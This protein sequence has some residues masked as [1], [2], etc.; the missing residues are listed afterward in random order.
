M[1]KFTIS[2]LLLAVLAGSVSAAEQPGEKTR[3]LHLLQDD[4]Q[5]KQV[6]KIYELKHVSANDLTPFVLSF[7]KR[8][9]V[10]STVE[11]LN[12]TAGKKELLVVSTPS[13]NMKYVDE[14]ITALDHPAPLDANGSV[15][16][17]TGI[18][19]F[20]YQP[21]YRSSDDIVTIINTTLRNKG[22]AYRDPV[23]NLIYWKDTN[24]VGKYILGWVQ[25]LDH[26]LPQAELIFRVYQIRKSDL[27]DVGIDYLAWKN[28]PGLNALSTGFDAINVNTVENALSNADIWSSWSYGGVFFAPSFDASFLRLLN[29]N[30]HAKIAAT[31]SLSVINNYNGN[32]YVKFSPEGQNLLKNDRDQTNVVT[33]ASTPFLLNIKSPVI[34]FRNAGEVD[35]VYEG[36]ITDYT[37]IQQLGGAI[38]FDYLFSASEVVERN[39]RGTELTD[40]TTVSSALTTDL[41]V[42]RL[43]AVYNRNEKAEQVIGV[44]FLVDVPVLK[45]LFSTTTN[46]DEDTKLFVTVTGRLLHPGDSFAPWSGRLVNIEEFQPETTFPKE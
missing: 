15:V 40:K 26:A 20:T 32:Y 30:G 42:E 34:T 24:A 41:G 36:N 18:Y 44:P 10:N 35:T 25:K 13:K 33:G 23:S 12:Y 8:Y 7:V 21:K 17:G 43:L 2:I 39:N 6:S 11:R 29:Q 3:R 9:N 28:G 37:K 5:E 38:Q 4:A 31:A 45:Y 1:N 46:I 14:I 16:S 27:K 19:R 22:Y